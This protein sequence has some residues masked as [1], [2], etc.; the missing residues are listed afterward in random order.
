MRDITKCHPKLQTLANQLVME[1]KKQG[2]II[3]IT[4][5]LRT[6]AEQDALYAKGRTTSGSIVTNARGSSF[7]SMHQ[8]GVAF[9]ICR[10][11]G[12]GAYND[13]DGF[14][15]KVGKIGTRLGL[16]WGGSW[17][18]PVDK[19]HFQLAEWGSTTSR[20][21]AKY[22]APD[23]FMKT[24][25]KEDDEMVENSEIIVNGKKIPVKRI[26]KDGTNYIKLRDVADAFGYSISNV[27]SI[28]KLDKK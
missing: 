15:T 20:L 18:S 11:D 28:A 14:F 5:C 27:G 2:L 9:D 1:C 10:N 13:A 19:P 6:T 21:K 17:T 24:W 25:K 22:G 16:E 8:W 12:K 23:N 7:S 4:E 26:M 3:K